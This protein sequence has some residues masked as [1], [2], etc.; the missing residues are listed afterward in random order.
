MHV[1]K[2]ISSLGAEPNVLMNVLSA[3]LMM[4]ILT[5]L[6]STAV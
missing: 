1:G 3:F 2:M 6:F 5:C 4:Y